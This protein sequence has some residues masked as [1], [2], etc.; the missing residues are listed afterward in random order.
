M[1]TAQ[2][3]A[4]ALSTTVGPIVENNTLATN[5]G[6]GQR[7]WARRWGGGGGQGTRSPTLHLEPSN[8]LGLTRA[9][10][11]LAPTHQ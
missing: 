7:W 9:A 11:A 6:H 5:A 1:A 8:W 4:L 2:E 3:M 10:L